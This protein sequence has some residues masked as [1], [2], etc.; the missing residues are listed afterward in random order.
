MT[1]QIACPICFFSTKHENILNQH[2][3]SVHAIEPE[4]L[5]KNYI[6]ASNL[7]GCGCNEIMKWHGWRRGYSKYIRGHN[8]SV[9]TSF[10]DPN[11]IERATKKRKE[12][13]ESGRFKVWN[14]G[15]TKETSMSLRVASEKKSET[16][17]RK[18]RDGELVPWQANPDYRKSI[19]KARM[20]RNQKL[21]SG[22]ITPWNKGL[23][24][25]AD[26]RI[27]S[28]GTKISKSLKENY[29]ASGRRLPIESVRKKIL[30]HANKFL[31]VDDLST[32]MNKYCKF[33]LQCK[34]CMQ[35]CEKTLS[36]LRN[37]P[38]CFN[39]HP[40]ES[41]GQLSIVDFIRSLDCATSV[42]D[43]SSI[44]PYELDIYIPELN[45]AIEY[46]GLYWHSEAGGRMKGYHA[47][48]SLRA[49]EKGIT[50]FHVFEDEWRDKRPIVESMIRY[51]LGK[52]TKKYYARKLTL[53]ALTQRDMQE[54]FN[55]THIDGHVRAETGFGLVD[56][57]GKIISAMSVRI[58]VQRKL[59][60]R[61]LEIARFSSMLN[62]LVVG[63]ASKLLS[64]V[65]QYAS[66]TQRSRIMTY[67]DVRHGTGR[68]YELS[69]MR[70]LGE[71]TER[72]WWSNSVRRF[73]RFKFKADKSRNM[74]ENEVAAESKVTRI[75]GCRNKIY[76][77]DVN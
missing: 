30:E 23:T 71:T 36:M 68:S 58:P 69:G 2:C 9:S 61:T 53:Q 38:I 72:F 37:C 66:E 48:K 39:C 21:K 74:T 41:Q 11:V 44:A 43:R 28:I 60:S 45:F 7:C 49:F 8:A 4:E 20:T 73:D 14:T 32:F 76:V 18:Y 34:N 17:R 62:T 57:N 10:S 24:R 65:R 3:V 40:K 13:L 46:N 27:R 15:L 67:V 31:L 33:K 75:W 77:L 55:A 19:E 56:E 52:V 5:Y 6:H 35:I 25:D 59:Y 51:R 1:T 22:E 70:L 16:S 50:L 64:A 26:E 54:F 29:A 47:D 12:G 63:G 42:S